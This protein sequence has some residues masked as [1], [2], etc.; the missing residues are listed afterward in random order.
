MRG[1]DKLVN[2]DVALSLGIGIS[3]KF[4]EQSL[5]HVIERELREEQEEVELA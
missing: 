5:E 4:H 1:M 3:C 2:R